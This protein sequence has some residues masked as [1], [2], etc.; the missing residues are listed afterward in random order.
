MEETPEATESRLRTPPLLLLGKAELFCNDC[1]GERVL[2]VVV[3]TFKSSS[4]SSMLKESLI[5]AIFTL[6]RESV[7]KAKKDEK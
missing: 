2:D 4:K 5:D 3:A 6:P 7:T 1:A